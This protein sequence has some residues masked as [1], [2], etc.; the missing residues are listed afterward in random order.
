MAHEHSAEKGP[1]LDASAEIEIHLSAARQ[2]QVSAE[3]QEQQADLQFLCEL[4]W[5]SG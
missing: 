1:H 3:D 4:A 5:E 2:W